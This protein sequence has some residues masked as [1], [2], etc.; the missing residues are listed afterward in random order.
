M[1]NS[2]SITLTSVVFCSF[3]MAKTQHRIVLAEDAPPSTS[4]ACTYPDGTTPAGRPELHCYG[5]PDFLK[6]YGIDK[7]QAA[8]LTGKGQTIILVD[9]FGSPTAQQDLDHFSDV[10]NLPHTT[11]QYVYPDGQFVNPMQNSDQVGWAQETTLDLEW[12]HAIAPDATIVN[13][14]SN[15]SETTGLT[16]FPDLFKGIDM[17]RQQYPK[18]IVSMSFGTGEATFNADDIK[19]YIQGSF[20][21][22]LQ[23][24]TDSGMTLLASAGD[25]GSTNINL[26]QTSMT[27]APDAGYP[28][29]DP[30]VTAVGGT[31]LQAGWTWNPQG[32]ADD[33]WKCKLANNANCPTDFMHFLSNTNTIIETVWKEDWALAAGGGGISKIFTAPA[34]QANLNAQVKKLTKGFRALPD[35]SMNAAINGGVNVYTSFSAPDGSVHGPT[36]QSYGGTSCA[37]PET[38]ALVALAGQRASNVLGKQVSIGSLNPVLYNLKSTDFRDIVAQPLGDK[39]QVVIDNNALYFNKDVLAS[40]GPTRLPPV[41]VPGYKTTPGYDMATGLG[42]PKVLSFVNN[43]A[44]ASVVRSLAD[45]L[46]SK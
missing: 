19:N 1:I 23:D 39:N 30:L 34:Y 44:G 33:F 43:L 45:D 8:G 20:H 25:S 41:A 42:S 40:L 16:G 17:A 15:T 24:A 32:T 4:T 36:W 2:R 21:Q 11:I 18:G 38:A 26:D 27:A 37:S 5:V 31:S 22:I 12:S 10:Y 3:A 13:V 7:L 35:V 29:S 14:I 6:A 9:S 46:A 28:A